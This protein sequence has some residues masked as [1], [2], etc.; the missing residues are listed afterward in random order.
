MIRSELIG[1]LVETH[2]HLP[3]PVVEAALNAIL[4]EIM[5]GLA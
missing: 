3:R 4:N 2:S 1:N 5:V